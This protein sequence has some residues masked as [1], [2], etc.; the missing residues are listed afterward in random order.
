MFWKLWFVCGLSNCLNVTFKESKIAKQLL[1]EQ[2][3]NEANERNAQNTHIV[4]G[5]GHTALILRIT[6]SSINKWLQ[7]R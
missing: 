4:Y 2:R 6:Q 5:M 3:V 1:A 7:W